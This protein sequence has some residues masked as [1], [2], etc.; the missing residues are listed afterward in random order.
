[1]SKILLLGL[2][3][4]WFTLQTGP[5]PPSIGDHPPFPYHLNDP[6]LAFDMPNEL[7]EI[8]GLSLTSDGQMLAAV[9]DEKGIIFLL[10]KSNG[11]IKSRIQFK[12]AGDYEGI[13]IVGNDAWVCKSNG[14]L[15]QVK[16]FAE[17]NP[18]VQSHK[19]F[20]DKENDLE[21]LAH[22]P[23]NNRLLIAC[24]G[25]S[26]YTDDAGDKKAIYAFDLATKTV[27]KTP[28]YLLTLSDLED[29]LKTSGEEDANKKLE[30]INAPGSGELKFSPSGIA[31]H[32]KTG[33][34]YITSARGNTLL[35][36]DAK[37]KV[38]HLERLK[39]SV[40]GQPEGIC[41]DADGTLFISNE[42]EDGSP[43]KIFGFYPK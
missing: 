22:D 6:D 24:K 36:L 35:V 27:S 34:I 10:D 18:E 5:L 13:E 7:K 39:K 41:F 43:G 11:A 42:G 15:Y 9:N 4:S 30:R 31:I 23:A 14:T 29:F 33:D 17:P 2:F 16:N 1:M 32:P 3:I 21:G 38:Q 20:L 26:G 8:S 25:H 28:A 19:S 40:H 12:D 37:G